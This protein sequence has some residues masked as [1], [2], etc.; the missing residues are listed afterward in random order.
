ME[1]IPEEKVNWLVDEEQEIKNNQPKFD[2]T[3]PMIIEEGKITEFDIDFS[4]PFEKWEDKEKKLFKAKIPVVHN[5]QKKLF[6]LNC[7]N[8]L[9][10]DL[11]KMGR[12]G[13]SHIKIT[14]TGQQKDT[15]YILLDK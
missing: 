4:K 5:N 11:I 13:K 3:P 7:R 15:R 9:Y 2:D 12:E 14:R 8:P 10:S 6:W 1:S